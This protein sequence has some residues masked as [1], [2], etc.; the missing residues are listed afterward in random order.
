MKF[1]S[2]NPE[3][4]NKGLPSS[5]GKLPSQQ[6]Q[7]DSRLI[8]RKTFSI[9]AFGVLLVLFFFLAFHSSSIAY[10]YY[11]WK[12]SR[13]D[14]LL[15]VVPRPLAT[16]GVSKLS[17]PQLSYYGVKFETPWKRVSVQQESSLVR[18]QFDDGQFVVLFDPTK[19]VNRLKVSSESALAKGR[20]ISEV[21]GRDAVKSNYAFLRAILYLTPDQISLFSGWK[22]FVRDGKGPVTG[23]I[24]KR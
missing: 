2:L 9:L 17:S 1:W 22:R 18:V 13:E 11:S 16:S 23:L 3:V 15:R 10:F 6:R 7:D 14:T 20:D 19:S 24:S 8:V 21:Y 4:E 12:L 5:S